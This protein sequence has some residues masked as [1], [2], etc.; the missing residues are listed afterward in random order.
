VA[1][2]S[3]NDD[4][5]AYWDQIAAR[6]EADHPGTRVLF[7]HQPDW[8]YKA[9]LLAMLGS[10]TPPDIMHTWGGGHLQALRD[11]G[12]VRD[13]STEMAEG[14]ALEFRPG[15]LQ[16]YT[17]DGGIYGVPSSVALVSLWVNAPLLARAGIPLEQLATWDGFLA[18]V[19]TLKAQGIVPLAV[20]GRDA[21]PFQ[22]IWG[23][24]ALEQGARAGFEA[25]YAG[26]GE[27]FLAPAYVAAGDRLR[28]LA[29]LDPFQEGFLE[30]DE[31]AAGNAFAEGRTAMV[32]TGNWRLHSMGWHWPGGPERMREEIRR[33]DFPG[34][35][36]TAGGP[37]T[38]GGVDGYAVNQRAPDIAVDLLRL[39]TS[40]EVQSRIAALTRTVPSVSGSD[41]A[42]GDPLVA[43]VADALLVS[44]YHQL[45]YDQ[46]LG[47][48][49]G[50][51]V[52]DVAMR[53]ATGSLTG[54]GA[55][56]L[57]EAAWDEAQRDLAPEPPVPSL[58]GAASP[59]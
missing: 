41:L 57:I 31:A 2:L 23:N 28:A 51:V 4:V 24:L 35:A 26:E 10:T 46:A 52:N 55:A 18:G 40:R 47:P 27:G 1:T 6:F 25:A 16:N 3:R 58:P 22:L 7:E 21:W 53:L 12:F 17:H 49:T 45:Y 39:L 37:M 56:R 50:A 13:L 38:Y 43:E 30:M 34:A 33:L 29:D 11:A 59:P 20:G 48:V 8:E 19:R 9:N 14:W 36:N 32:V 5:H 15:A 44:G 42:L 54:I